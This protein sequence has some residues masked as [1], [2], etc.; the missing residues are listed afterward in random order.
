MHGCSAEEPVAK[1]RTTR[2]GSRENLINAGFCPIQF[3]GAEPRPN[4]MLILVD[5]I[6]LQAPKGATCMITA[7]WKRARLPR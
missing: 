3:N 2:T 5:T 6:S 1:S 7:G 4:W